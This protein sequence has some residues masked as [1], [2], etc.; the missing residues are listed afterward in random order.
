LKKVVES[1]TRL[2]DLRAG[3]I[4]GF[5]DEEFMLRLFA[6]NNLERLV[7]HRTDVTD[8]SLKVLVQGVDPEIDLLTGRPIVPPRKLKHLDLH[9]CTRLT[10]A[11][12]RALAH[13]V[14][15]LEGL[16]LSQ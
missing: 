4:L 14:P 11:G 15:D 8:D 9:H 12:V 7:M 2:K 10:D 5:D 6:T 3:E 13:N 16:Q 1:C